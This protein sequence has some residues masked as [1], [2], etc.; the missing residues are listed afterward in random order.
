MKTRSDTCHFPTAMFPVHRRIDLPSE[1]DE[2]CRNVHL[3]L[4]K[5]TLLHHD[6]S[7]LVPFMN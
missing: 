4:K 1:L 2:Y 3:V 6:Q 5:T 7:N